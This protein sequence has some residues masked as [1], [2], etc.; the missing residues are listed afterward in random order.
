MQQLSLLPTMWQEITT[1]DNLYEAYLKARKGKRQRT[2]VSMFSRDL[3]TNLFTLQDAL[4]MQHYTPGGYRQFQ[5]YDRKPRVISVAP[6]LDRVVHHALIGL[7][8][9]VFEG[10]FSDYCF[11]CRK[12]KGVHAAINYYQTQC[13][14]YAYVL[15]MDVKRYF[16]SINHVLMKQRYRQLI[17]EPHIL[18]LLDRII[19]S[20]NQT[21]GLPIGNLTSQTLANV[22]L[23][24]VDKYLEQQSN[25]R[26][27]R[28]VDDI[29]VL[30]N[31]KKELWRI[32]SEIRRL[33][34]QLKL[35]LHENKTHIFRTCEKVDVLGY[36]VTP[37]KRWLHNQNGYRFQRWLRQ[38]AHAYAKGNLEL[39]AITPSVM[40]WLGHAQHGQTKGLRQAL[41][42]SVCFTRR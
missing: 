4:I 17:H 11:A 8:E 6:F 9:P 40:S 33:C 37:N 3:E 25:V 39:S 19:D 18:T 13:R 34:A 22:Y 16:P 15:K 42:S 10:Y 21:T 23:T 29:F 2:D 24:P 30:A 31:C 7:L 41:F 1:L 35:E 20:N 32:A 14:R 28:Y 5:I 38:Q 26:F 27:L 12:G 36:K